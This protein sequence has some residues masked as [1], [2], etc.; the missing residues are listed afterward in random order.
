[1]G[2]PEASGPLQGGVTELAYML[3]MEVVDS[4]IRVL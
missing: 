1:M 4:V 3:I 2:R